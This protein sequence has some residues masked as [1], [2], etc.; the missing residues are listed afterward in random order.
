MRLFVHFFLKAGQSGPKRDFAHRLDKR[1]FPNAFAFGFVHRGR[2]INGKFVLRVCV[3]DLLPHILR[4]HAAADSFV[5]QVR[6][7]MRFAKFCNF[8][9]ARAFLIFAF[10]ASLGGRGIAHLF[11]NGRFFRHL[12]LSCFDN[13]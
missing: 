2:G 8:Q 7:P 1:I 9:D 12:F 6:F 13:F 5:G 3:K 11:V 4:S 10:R